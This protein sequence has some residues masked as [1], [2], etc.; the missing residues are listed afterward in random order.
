MIDWFCAQQLPQAQAAAQFC[1]CFSFE[2]ALDHSE[3]VGKTINNSNV[4]QTNK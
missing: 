4:K 1:F 3:W 2:C